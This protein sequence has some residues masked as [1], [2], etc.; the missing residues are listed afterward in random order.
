MQTETRARLTDIF[1]TAFAGLELAPKDKKQLNTAARNQCLAAAACFSCEDDNLGDVAVVLVAPFLEKHPAAAPDG[2]SRLRLQLALR[3]GIIVVLLREHALNSM[4]FEGDFYDAPNKLRLTVGRAGMTLRTIGESESCAASL[5][6]PQ[7]CAGELVIAEF[8][9][10]A[11][12]EYLVTGFKWQ[13]ERRAAF[14]ICRS[15][16]DDR[17]ELG[18]TIQLGHESSRGF[19]GDEDD[20]GDVGIWVSLRDSAKTLLEFISYHRQRYYG[21]NNAERSELGEYTYDE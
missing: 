9:A 19:S 2:D 6:W 20:N 21:A 7:V 1:E 15:H 10:A 3:L 13:G 5:S 17:A 4:E 11:Q 8:V 14:E 12:P 16:D 18:I